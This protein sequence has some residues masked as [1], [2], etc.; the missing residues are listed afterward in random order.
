MQ[1]KISFDLIP[2]K[3][4]KKVLGDTIKPVPIWDD[5]VKM[6]D[7]DLSIY[8]CTSSILAAVRQAV[9]DAS[10][11]YF[12]KSI[13]NVVLSIASDKKT[14]L[15]QFRRLSGT[16]RIILPSV[17]L[18][19]DN[20]YPIFSNNTNTR[21]QNQ[22]YFHEGNRY[23][24]SFLAIPMRF[25]LSMRY[26]ATNLGAVFRWM[27]NLFFN[28]QVSFPEKGFKYSVRISDDDKNPQLGYVTGT[29]KFDV[30]EKNYTPSQLTIS[31]KQSGDIWYMEV[32]MTVWA[33][34]VSHPYYRPSIT[35][36]QQT[37]SDQNGEILTQNTP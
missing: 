13:N 34:L 33:T 7:S 18:S 24:L 6:P 1:N 28:S 5:N 21:I 12:D 27:D 3:V 16:N 36:V 8:S 4:A 19:L 10:V 29:I 26:Y 15:L 37:I 30:L 17:A 9:F 22:M 20:Y 25:E 31:Q 14:D 11:N 35:T 2:S 23:L 32:P